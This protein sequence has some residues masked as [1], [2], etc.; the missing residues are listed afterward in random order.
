MNFMIVEMSTR[1]N[2]HRVDGGNG[3]QLSHLL[4]CLVLLLVGHLWVVCEAD[5]KPNSETIKEC[6]K[7]R[8]SRCLIVIVIVINH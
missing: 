7:K 5:G 3:V 4:L 6:M 1:L 8:T 2:K